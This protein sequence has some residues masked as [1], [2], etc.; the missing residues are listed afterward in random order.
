MAEQPLKWT[1]VYSRHV[2][3]IAFGEDGLHAI[4]QDRSHWVYPDAGQDIFDLLE[5]DSS[6]GHIM[7]AIVKPL[8]GASAYRIS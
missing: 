2:A 4:F 6:P 5:S 3:Q 1:E 7:H 8:Y